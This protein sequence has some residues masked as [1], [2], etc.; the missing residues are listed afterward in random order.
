MDYVTISRE[1]AMRIEMAMKLEGDSCPYCGHEWTREDMDTV[2]FIVSDVDLRPCHPE[3]WEKHLQE[4]DL[5]DSLAW[6]WA[7]TSR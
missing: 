3:C 1:S 5:A 7:V 2:D 6:T 4:L